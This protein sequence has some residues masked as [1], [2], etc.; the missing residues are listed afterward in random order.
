[1]GAPRVPKIRGLPRAFEHVAHTVNPIAEIVNKGLVVNSTSVIA[2][3][4][5]DGRVA[6]HLSPSFIS[7]LKPITAPSVTRVVYLAGAGYTAGDVLSAD[8]GTFTVQFT[9]MIDAVDGTGTPTA[10]HWGGGY[11]YTVEPTNPVDFLGGTGSGAQ[12]DLTWSA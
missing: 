1:M 7:S 2:E 12:F 10:W 3:R 4:L 8:G 6:L 5:A 9:L 11:I